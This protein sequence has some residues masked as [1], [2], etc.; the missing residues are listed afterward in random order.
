MISEGWTFIDVAKVVSDTR[1]PLSLSIVQTGRSKGRKWK[2]RERP[3][4]LVHWDGLPPSILPRW[5]SLAS[6]LLPVLWIRSHNVNQCGVVSGASFVFFYE[7][8]KSKR[9]LR[10]EEYNWRVSVPSENQQ[11]S[12]KIHSAK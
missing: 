3:C 6:F 5:V 1:A 11:R 12:F 4:L 10:R 2:R 8:A 7:K 9:F